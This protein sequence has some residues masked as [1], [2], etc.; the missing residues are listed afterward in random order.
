MPAA[1]AP[2]TPSLLFA[3]LQH[4]DTLKTGFSHMTCLGDNCPVPGQGARWVAIC[5]QSSPSTPWVRKP[6]AEVTAVNLDV[7]PLALVCS[8][9]P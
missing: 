1:A 2:L 7:P 4:E 6:M 5:P 9:V 3:S 8:E